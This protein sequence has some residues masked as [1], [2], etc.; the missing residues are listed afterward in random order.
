[1]SLATFLGMGFSG[2]A[3]LNRRTI[4]LLSTSIPENDNLIKSEGSFSSDPERSVGQIPSQNRRSLTF[5]IPTSVCPKT[6]PLIKDLTYG[7]RNSVDIDRVSEVPF[8]M[9]VASGEGYEGVAY[10]DDLSLTCQPQNLMQMDITLTSW[11][12]TDISF[13][14]PIVRDSH[15]LLPLSDEYKPIAGWQT[16]PTMTAI[17]I[18]STPLNWSLKLNNNWQYQSFLGGYL[19]APN[20]ELIMPGPLE[21]DLNMTWL[22]N[23]QD[24]P[25]RVGTATLQIG[26]P[27][28]TTI[29]IP[30]LIRQPARQADGT[31]DSGNY[32]KWTANFSALGASPSS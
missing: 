30:R 21:V 13:P 25:Q 19:S 11:I 24:R 4:P 20:P 22:A 18:N 31:G 14:V 17:G 8:K 23:R 16:I 3:V 9:V 32:L 26:V 27:A 29:T 12:W 2:Y 7:W 1:V 28:Q 10:V 5:T 6:V 15:A